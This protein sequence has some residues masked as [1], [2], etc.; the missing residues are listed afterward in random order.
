MS[1]HP[2]PPRHGYRIRTGVHAELN[3]G[4]RTIACEAQ[5]LSR[6]GVLLVG[7][8]QA[9]LE[10]TVDL[11]LI[12]PTGSL[13]V[14]VSGRVIRVEPGLEGEGVRMALEFVDMD[15]SRR[16][17]IEV[18]VARL[19]EATP[20]AK[21]FDQ[22]KP[23]APPQEIKK[24]LEAIPLPQRISMSSRAPLKDRE[25]LRADTNPAVLEA[26][27]HNPNLSLAEARALAASVYLLPGTLDALANDARFKDD[28]VLRMAVAA[29]P[30]VSLATAEKVTA[31]FKVPQIKKLLAKP[32]LNQTLREKLFRRTQR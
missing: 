26:L 15:D 27:A 22:L 1:G 29:H 12:S 20:A 10:E 4:K 16:D 32:G 8:L 31:D 21:S 13:T 9:P 19:L 5:N 23:G 30:R 25:I 18:F 17:A 28:E 24:A 14:R 11:A 2:E 3:D 6:S 7:D